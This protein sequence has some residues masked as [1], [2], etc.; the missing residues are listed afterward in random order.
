MQNNFTEFRLTRG[1]VMS[2]RREDECDRRRSSPVRRRAG[3]VDADEYDADPPNTELQGIAGERRDTPLRVLVG[4][5]R[6]CSGGAD[7][8]ARARFGEGG[9]RHWAERSLRLKTRG[10]GRREGVADGVSS[11][12]D[13]MVE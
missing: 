8:D 1:T 12:K 6:R 11:E 13:C 4:V 5:W 3:T 7:G 9:K 2:R 10:D